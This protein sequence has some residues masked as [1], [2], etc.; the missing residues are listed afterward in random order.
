MREDASTLNTALRRE[1]SP[2]DAQ[3]SPQTIQVIDRCEEI[4]GLFSPARLAI[5]LLDLEQELGMQRSTAH[6]YLT[7]LAANGFLARVDEGYCPGPLMI[8]LGTIALDS[9]QV[10]DIA[11]PYMRRL[12]GETHETC[13][14]SIW[15]GRG[16]VIVRVV[17]D[18]DK[19]VHVLV[20]IGATLDIDSA[21]ARIFLAFLNDQDLNRR[22][23]SNLPAHLASEVLA[24]LPAI[25]E[26]RLA[27]NATLV[28]GVR[29][30]AA[31]ILDRQERIMAAIA[32]VGTMQSV[33]EGKSSG[34]AL[35]VAHTAQLLS[36]QLGQAPNPNVRGR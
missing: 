31:P 35:S 5:R 3:P 18:M 8:K 11:D 21:Q 12:T 32:V 7:S 2:D 9:Q 25:R 23:T 16:P 10:L 19:V 34:L 6:R 4:L 27:V 14:M 26:S 17:E 30:I 22:L 28:R 24:S 36:E 1:P 13:V 33:P 20:R 29:T 15:G